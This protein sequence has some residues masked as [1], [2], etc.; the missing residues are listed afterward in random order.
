MGNKNRGPRKPVP[1][2]E[3]PT[4]L[5]DIGRHIVYAEGTRTEPEYVK[6]IEKEIRKIHRFRNE[7]INI[8]EIGKKASGLDTLRLVEFAEKDL[9]ERR[10]SGEQYDYVWLF[11]DLDQFPYSDFLAAIKKI[12]DKNN[13]SFS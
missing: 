7:R 9:A 8:I 5:I 3:F 6:S 11:F 10:N 1:R 13:D 4:L 2:E 12:E